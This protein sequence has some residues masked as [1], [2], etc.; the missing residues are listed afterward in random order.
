MKEEKM[1]M[2]TPS[3]DILKTLDE[4]L[5]QNRKILEINT[6][7]VKSLMNPPMIIPEKIS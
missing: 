6:E 1:E 5:A 4:I 3:K 2:I 7:I